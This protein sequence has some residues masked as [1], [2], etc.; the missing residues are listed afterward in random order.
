M[1]EVL[2]VQ[3]MRDSDAAT[4]AGG[5][6]GRELMMRAGRGIYEAVEWQGPVAILCGSGNNAGDGYVVAELLRQGGVE[7]TLFLLSEKWSEDGRYYYDICVKNKIPVMLWK[8]YQG[9]F[10]EF[11]EILD[12]L[13]G[14]GFHGPVRGEA[15]ELIDAVNR[16]RQMRMQ[17]EAGHAGAAGTPG[18][19]RAGVSVT[20]NAGPRVISVD[21][22]SGLGGNSGLGDP[23]IIS[24]LTISIGNFQPGH[25]LNRAMDVM[26]Q[27]MNIEIGIP[28]LEQPYHLLEERDVAKLFAPREHFAHKGKYGYV[29]LI[30]GAGNEDAARVGDGDSALIGGSKRYSGALRLANLANAAMRSGAGVVKLAFPAEIYPQVAGNLLEST[31]FPLRDA[32]GEIAFEEAQIR[33]LIT[34]VKTVTFGMGVGL[35]EGAARVLEYLL[36]HYKGRLI[37]DADGLTLLSR[38][39]REK[40]KQAEAEVLL[41]PHLME[42]SRLS[43]LPIEEIS[44]DPIRHAMDYGAEMGVTV[45]LKG[46]TTVITD[47]QQVYLTDRGS[48]GMATAGSG[49]VLSGVLSAVCAYLPDPV[50]AAAAGAYISGMAGEEAAEENG[51]I[52]MTAGDTARKLTSVIKKLELAEG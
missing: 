43:G 42:F 3:N 11:G 16:A 40:I 34:H 47:G 26:V 21:I 41:T 32:E 33:E 37:V 31:A 49:D 39:D 8:E 30:G 25:F 18:T 15:A 9:D 51:T 19:D 14:T 28:P 2:S 52:S 50:M 46:P 35:G 4:I 13:Y 27:K 5:I 23:C 38:M 1:I 6:P 29:A 17:A 12:C 36:S 20:R 22:N 44:E 10:S 45:L 7:A 48:G 24:D